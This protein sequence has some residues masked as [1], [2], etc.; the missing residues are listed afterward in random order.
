MNHLRW[1]ARRGRFF[2]TSPS[3]SGAL[4]AIALIAGIASIF[5]GH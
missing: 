2:S 4:V 5:W 1:D 3:L